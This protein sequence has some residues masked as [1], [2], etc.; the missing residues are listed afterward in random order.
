MKRSLELEGGGYCC[1]E[2]WNDQTIT[3]R[4]DFLLGHSN[5]VLGL[6]FGFKIMNWVFYAS[7][8]GPYSICGLRDR[9]PD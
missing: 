4:V 5:F 6:I 8:S 9:K 1:L 7:G 2:F 3:L